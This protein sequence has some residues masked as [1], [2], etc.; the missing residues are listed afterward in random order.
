MNVLEGDPKAGRYAVGNRARLVVAGSFVQ[1]LV[2]P[3]RRIGRIAVEDVV[4]EA[5]I[6]LP[7]ILRGSHDF[8]LQVFA[9]IQKPEPHI[10]HEPFVGAAG[11]AI[12]TGPAHID[13]NAAGGLND[14]GVHISA[15]SMGQIADCFE[16]VLEAV[17]IR[18]EGDSDQPGL[19]IDH[20]FHIPHINAP[21]ARHDNPEF[22][23]LLLEFPVEV[24]GT[25]EMERIGDDI[26]SRLR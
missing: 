20:L 14:V 15:V 4:L 23:A 18:D 8:P 7:S 2:C 11:R 12:N 16:I 5:A 13:G 19:S 24:E 17:D 3:G 6:L 1:A 22:H 21:V 10:A 26:A 9:D 25:L